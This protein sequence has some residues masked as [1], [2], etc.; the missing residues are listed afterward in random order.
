MGHRRDQA[1]T[2]QRSASHQAN[3]QAQRH[4]SLGDHAEVRRV[5]TLPAQVVTPFNRGSE[6]RCVWAKPPIAATAMTIS[7]SRRAESFAVAHHS[8]CDLDA[9]LTLGVEA[10]ASDE[11]RIHL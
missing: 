10:L 5:E 2:G 8:F 7:A 11:S 4:R 9:A 3:A 1:I 6:N